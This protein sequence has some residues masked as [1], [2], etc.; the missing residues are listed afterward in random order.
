MEQEH[1]ETNAK[2]RAKLRPMQLDDVD[3]V[4]TID[5]QS[6]NLPW[7]KKSYIFELTENHASASWVAEVVDETGKPQVVGMIVT[8]FII[9]EV[10]IATIAVHPEYR[11]QGIGRRLL[12]HAILHSAY[13]GANVAMLEV[14]HT[15]LNAQSL[16]Q[17]FGFK[18]VGVRKNYYKDNNEDAFMMNLDPIVVEAVQRLEEP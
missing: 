9:D 1:A 11:H 15:N 14:R 2:R 3:Q 16:Y 8:W 6:F 7:T 12:A 4:Y 17:Q 5:A 10:H 18:V 13:K